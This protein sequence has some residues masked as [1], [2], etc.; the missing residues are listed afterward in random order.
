MKLLYFAWFRTKIGVAGESVE[1]PPEITTVGQL[2]PW[3]AARG[4]AYADALADPSIVRVA[5][6]EEYA[7]DDD[8]VSDGDEVALF[9]PVTGGNVR[10]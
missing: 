8:A 4:P 7:R 9:P 6:N 10:P 5:V 1:L 3:L 2:I